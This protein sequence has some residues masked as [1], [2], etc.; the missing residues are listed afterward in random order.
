MNVPV[1][2]ADV[3]ANAY[4]GADDDGVLAANMVKV[5]RIDRHGPKIDY[6]I[7]VEVRRLGRL[8]QKKK[9]NYIVNL[10]LFHI[11]YFLLK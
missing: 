1:V 11:I 3:D 5:E 7:R 10:Q 4:A 2:G 6:P 9:S 8:K